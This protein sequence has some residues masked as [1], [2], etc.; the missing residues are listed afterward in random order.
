M[1]N[2]QWEVKSKNEKLETRHQKLNFL[3]GLLPR[4]SQL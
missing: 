4:D 1:R 2:R 3:F